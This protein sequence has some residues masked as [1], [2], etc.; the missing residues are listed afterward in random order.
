MERGDGAEGPERTRQRAVPRSRWFS[1]Y[2]EAAHLYA[3][4]HSRGLISLYGCTTSTARCA[5]RERSRTR[6][7]LRFSEID[8]R[9]LADV[10]MTIERRRFANVCEEI[11]QRD[12]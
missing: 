5:G 9:L 11:W 3:V 1:T 4:A 10:D 6:S 2:D 8:A 7:R 12:D